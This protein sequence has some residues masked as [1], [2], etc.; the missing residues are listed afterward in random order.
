MRPIEMAQSQQ[1]DVSVTAAPDKVVQAFLDE[2]KRLRVD[3]HIANLTSVSRA[4]RRRNRGG[5][6]EGRREARPAA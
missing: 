2:R 5:G 3:R 6:R 4:L 1:R